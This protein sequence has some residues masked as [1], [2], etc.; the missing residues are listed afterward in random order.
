MDVGVE[1]TRKRLLHHVDSGVELKYPLWTTQEALANAVHTNTFDY[2]TLL[3]LHLH[4]WLM[5]T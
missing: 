1:C 3:S 4:A 5:K 2:F